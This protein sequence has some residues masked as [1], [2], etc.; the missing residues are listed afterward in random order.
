MRR[1]EVRLLYLDGTCGRLSLS[2]AQVDCSATG[3]WSQ[4]EMQFFSQPQDSP[5]TFH[6]RAFRMSPKKYTERSLWRKEDGKAVVTL[7]KK[8]PSS[9]SGAYFTVCPSVNQILCL[10][11]TPFFLTQ[12]SRLFNLRRLQTI[13][14]KYKYEV[15]TKGDAVSRWLHVCFFSTPDTRGASATWGPVDES[16]IEI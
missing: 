4:R 15:T 3:C 11:G 8:S 14:Y 13:I 2:R 7:R 10:P 1:R 16:K 6:A 12:N 9:R 5:K